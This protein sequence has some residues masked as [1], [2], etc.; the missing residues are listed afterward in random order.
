MTLRSLPIATLTVLTFLPFGAVLW[1]L[2]TATNSLSWLLWG[3]LVAPVI[4]VSASAPRLRVR[5]LTLWASILLA[6]LLLAGGFA[7]Y[8][9]W[10][11]WSPYGTHGDFTFAALALV[12]A[13]GLTTPITVG[14]AYFQPH[15]MVAVAG[16]LLA[17]AL[18]VAL[19]LAFPEP[20]VEPYYRSDYPNAIDGYSITTDDRI[21]IL[22]LGGIGAAALIGAGVLMRR[23]I[24]AWVTW[25]AAIMFFLTAAT[26]QVWY[27]PRSEVLFSG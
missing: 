17:Q 5:S 2:S 14:A 23:R 6:V 21:L 3:A 27:P 20:G 9:A 18:F 16:M 10:D 12:V 22:V 1:G 15:L 13:G 24:P 19:T 25:P 7:S 11:A 8:D 26:Y 4:F